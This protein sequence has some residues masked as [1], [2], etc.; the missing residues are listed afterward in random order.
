MPALAYAVAFADVAFADEWTLSGGDVPAIGL[1]LMM[2]GAGGAAISMLFW[3]SF[4]PCGGNRHVHERSR[5]GR[6][7]SHKGPLG[8]PLGVTGRPF[9]V[10]PS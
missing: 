1:I 9:V 2:V 4:A 6:W 3:T 8:C 7:S 5:I 10:L